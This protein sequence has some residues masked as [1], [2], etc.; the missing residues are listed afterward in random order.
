MDF[1]DLHVLVNGED[2]VADGGIWRSGGVV[3]DDG[4]IVAVAASCWLRGLE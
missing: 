4:E 1:A 3:S 2:G